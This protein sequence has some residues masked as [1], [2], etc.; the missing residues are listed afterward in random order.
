MKET[1][2]RIQDERAKERDRIKEGK[3]IRIKVRDKAKM[4]KKVQTY[5]RQT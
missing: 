1:G 3:K 5:V 4:K 2:A